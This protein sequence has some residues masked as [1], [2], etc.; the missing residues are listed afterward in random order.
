M[1]KIILI[2]VL[3]FS[4]YSYSFADW[5]EE[6]FTWSC[7]FESKCINDRIDDLIKINE[8]LQEDNK[9]LQN[10]YTEFNSWLESYV[11]VIW[12]KSNAYDIWINNIF[13]WIKWYGWILSILLVA[14]WIWFGFYKQNEIKNWKEEILDWIELQKEDLNKYKVELKDYNK[15]HFTMIKESIE[16]N[17]KESIVQGEM[18]KSLYKKLY[19]DLSEQLENNKFNNLISEDIRD[20]SNKIKEN[21]DKLDSIFEWISK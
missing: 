2:F 20:E 17:L 16:I 6:C 10:N 12:E 14:I 9:A 5:W 7:C 3:L 21:D 18:F 8:K 15:E 4:F 1:Q 11:K 19:N 13:N